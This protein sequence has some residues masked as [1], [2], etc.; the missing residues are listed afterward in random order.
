MD[1]VEVVVR[2]LDDKLAKDITVIDMQLASPMFDHFIIATAS[3]ERLLGAIVDNV[4]DEMEKNGYALKRR[5][6]IRGS[7]WVLLDFGDCVVHVFDEEERKAYNIEKLWAD[8]PLVDID[9]YLN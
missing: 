8:M 6:G 2:A 5:E 7:K 9:A 4:E 1:K 3:N